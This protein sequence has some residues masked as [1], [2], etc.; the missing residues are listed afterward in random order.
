MKI[1][2]L[3]DLSF[4]AAGFFR[5]VFRLIYLACSFFALGHVSTK[6]TH[7]LKNVIFFSLAIF[8]RPVYLMVF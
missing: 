5:L 7:F 6:L 3:F 2:F 1:F 8:W 4:D